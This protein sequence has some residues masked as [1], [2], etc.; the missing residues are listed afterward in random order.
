VTARRRGS[1]ADA[2]KRM[3]KFRD[4]EKAP[5]AKATPAPSPVDGDDYER[6]A[7]IERRQITVYLRTQLYQQ[8]RAAIV[9]LGKREVGPPSISAMLDR[10]LERELQRLAEQYNDGEPW[11]LHKG[12]LPGG[13]TSKG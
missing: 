9:E 8:A 3:Q 12:R 10:A 5:A 7:K 2:T 6:P 11:P 1:L 4:D 13:T